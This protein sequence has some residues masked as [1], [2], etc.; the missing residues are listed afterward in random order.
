MDYW[1]S[2]AS[3]GESVTY[4]LW[5]EL[6]SDLY[7]PGGLANVYT[8]HIADEDIHFPSSQLIAWL[9]N[10]YI[11]EIRNA[12]DIDSWDSNE[13]HSSGLAWDKV[14]SKWVAVAVG[15]NAGPAQNLSNISINVNKDWGSYDITNLGGLELA[16]DI[17]VDTDSS[18][19]I[20]TN[21]SRVA[22]I[23]CDD[24]WGNPH[25]QDMYFKETWC[26]ICKETF[27]VGD[28]IILIV[29]SVDKETAS[30][31]I[32]LKCGLKLG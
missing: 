31:P 8:T 19:D 3:P 4:Q 20:G 14:S 15:S 26:D 7:Y 28:A 18:Y 10:I 5:N 6:V 16:G 27:K 32:H 12:E 11:K 17:T 13:F 1:Y 25:Y 21:T 29:K 9:D 24:L 30:V 22:N 23:Y 2:T